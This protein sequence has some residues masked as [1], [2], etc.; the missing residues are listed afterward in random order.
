MFDFY[1]QINAVKNN[2]EA[3]NVYFSNLHNFTTP[4][5]KGSNITFQEIMN[6][7]TGMGVGAMRQSRNVSFTQGSIQ[8]T[9]LPTDLAINGNGFFVLSDGYKNHYTRAGRFAF[10]DGKMVEP[11]SGMSLQGYAL[12]QYGN[13]TTKLTDINLSFDPVTKLYGGK[14]TGFHFD[15][16]GK[17]YGEV[18]FTDPLT[19]QS[20]TQSVPLYQVAVASFA[21]PSGL[22]PTGTTTFTETEASGQAVV[23]VSGQG[24]LGQVIAQSLEMSNI[25]IADQISQ[26][27]LARQNY[28]ANFAAFKAMDRMRETAIGLIK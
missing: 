20:V 2:Q 17:L 8:R 21:N 16:G 15:N 26:I 9:G 6:Q 28:E 11:S 25:T 1:K 7:S 24:A 5:Y 27:M 19:Q 3:M 14:Y 4:G 23:G 22:K 18:R 10:K 13:P 12:D